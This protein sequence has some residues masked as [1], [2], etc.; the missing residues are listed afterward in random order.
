MRTSASSDAA[1]IFTNTTCEEQ[2][3]QPA[4]LR[5]KWIQVYDIKQAKRE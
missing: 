4:F 2:A 1:F 3:I 5:C